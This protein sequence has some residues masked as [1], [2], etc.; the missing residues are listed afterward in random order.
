MT[1]SDMIRRLLSEY[2]NQRTANELALEGRI[3]EAGRM[4]PEII[5]LRNE[6][7]DLAFETM[8]KIM[9][10]PTEAEKREAALQMKQRG[11]FNNGEIRRRLAAAGL[12][13]NHLDLQYRCDVCRDTAYVGEAPSRFCDCFENRLRI[14]QYEDGSMSGTDEQ[15]FARFDLNR[16]PVEN[17]Q[18]AA[19]QGFRAA[20]E[21]YAD[22]FPA[23]P[24]TNILLLGTSGLGKT[25]L[26][27]CIYERVVSRGYA[28]VR[29]S[30]FRMFEAMRKQHFANSPEDCEFD[31]LVSAPLLLIDDLGS[32]PMM[33]NITVEYLFTLLNE[34][35]NA[36]RHTVIATNLSLEE[37][38]QTYGDRVYSRLI[39]HSRWTHFKFVGKDLRRL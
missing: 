1:K 12:P 24:F 28:A 38:K 2:Q 11:I 35:M 17:N 30:A 25:F 19:M 23:T 10:L 9:S 29:V 33:R 18:R 7:R 32:E 37:I 13:E 39:D 4:D 3:A 16:I 6:N 34:R 21:D 8:K 36:R 5:R 31:Q 20:A 27:N 22:T 15:C 14:M 26:L